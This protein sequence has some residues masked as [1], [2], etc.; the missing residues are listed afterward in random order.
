MEDQETGASKKT[1]KM[2]PIHDFVISKTHQML[3]IGYVIDSKIKDESRKADFMRLHKGLVEAF[4]SYMKNEDMDEDLQEAMARMCINLQAPS[5]TGKTP[6]ELLFR[7]KRRE[8]KEFL[9][10]TGHLLDE[11]IDARRTQR[12]GIRSNRVFVLN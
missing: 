9:I 2:D 10:T 4:T 8:D 5:D 3:G 12:G 7:G 6:I 11:L 1:K